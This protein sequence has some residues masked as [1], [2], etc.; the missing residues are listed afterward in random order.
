MALA[1]GKSLGKLF[2]AYTKGLL[3]DMPLATAEGFHA[4]P[5]LWGDQVPDYG[6]VTNVQSGFAV[7]GKSLFLGMGHGFRD[8]A[9]QPAEGMAKEGG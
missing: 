6:S 2:S 9:R 1:S 8:L 4:L 5:R 3:V 7:A